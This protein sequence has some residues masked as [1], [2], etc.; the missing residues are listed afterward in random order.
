MAK[1]KKKPMQLSTSAGFLS[2][3]IDEELAG[4]KV[5]PKQAILAMLLV[6]LVIKIVGAFLG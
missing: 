2:F 3:S 6:S 5:S 1:I 4:L